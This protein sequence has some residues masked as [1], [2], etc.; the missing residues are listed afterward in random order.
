M[1]ND[2]MNGE[3]K[4]HSQLKYGKQWNYLFDAVKYK[5]R[6]IEKTTNIVWNET[7]FRSILK[8]RTL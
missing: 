6:G 2:E 1:L 5:S 4:T 3:V 7:T 8:N